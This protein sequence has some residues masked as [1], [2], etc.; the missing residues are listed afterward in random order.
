MCLAIPFSPLQISDVL[1][2]VTLH[3]SFL[4]TGG[5]RQAAEYRFPVDPDAA[6]SAL[7]VRT[8]GRVI[9]GAVKEKQA[10]HAEYNAAVAAGHGAYLVQESVA[11]RDVFV[12]KCA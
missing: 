3:Q 10:A 11:S 9:R 1:A 7:E 6:V 5:E 12:M 2:Q 4:H 8:G